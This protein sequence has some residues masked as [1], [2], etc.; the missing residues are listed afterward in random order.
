MAV[1]VWL[2]SSVHL[3]VGLVWDSVHPVASQVEW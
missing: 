2:L 3:V 1:A